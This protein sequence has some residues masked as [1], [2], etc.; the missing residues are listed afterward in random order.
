[1][2][3]TNKGLFELCNLP[4]TFQWINSILW[5]LL[6]EEVLENYI[7]NFV[8]Y[9]NQEETRKKNNMI[10]KYDRE[11]QSLFQTVKVWFYC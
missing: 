8:I 11:T 5:E 2:E 1:V 6:Y 9:Q 10:L 4:E 7:N 3:L